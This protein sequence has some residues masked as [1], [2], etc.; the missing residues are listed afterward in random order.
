MRK[1]IFGFT[2]LSTAMKTKLYSKITDDLPSSIGLPL[3]V[4]YID[5]D[6]IANNLDFET[7]S[8]LVVIAFNERKRVSFYPGVTG[9]RKHILL[10]CSIF[11]KPYE[12]KVDK[13]TDG[14]LHVDLL[15]EACLTTQTKYHKKGIFKINTEKEYHAYIQIVVIV[16]AKVAINLVIKGIKL[17]SES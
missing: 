9:I 12:P 2:H 16:K 15:F 5:E 1:Y 11:E 3:E 8:E 6:W 10:D 4:S 13:L 7:I 17:T 14:V